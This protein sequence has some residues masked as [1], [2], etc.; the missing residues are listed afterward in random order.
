MYIRGKRQETEANINLRLTARTGQE[1][2]GNR[3]SGS[4]T[5]ETKT[6]RGLDRIPDPNITNREQ[7]EVTRV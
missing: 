4:H 6:R 2:A 7:Y 1:T 5:T 3:I